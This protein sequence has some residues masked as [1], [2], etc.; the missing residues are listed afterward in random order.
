MTVHRLVISSYDGTYFDG[1]R[2]KKLET[3][4]VAR[5]QYMIYQNFI[6]MKNMNLYL[7]L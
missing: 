6:I 2:P 5:N 1:L 3:N 7:E 4:F